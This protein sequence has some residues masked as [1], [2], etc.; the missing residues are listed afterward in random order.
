MNAPANQPPDLLTSGKIA[1]R[2]Q[3]PLHRVLRVLATRNHIKP[4]A[5]A[6]NLRLYNSRAVAMVRHELIAIDARR[7][8]QE[9]AQC[10]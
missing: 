8:R 4:A 1:E 9:V 3:Q 5:R 10:Q 7:C 6:G 2:L